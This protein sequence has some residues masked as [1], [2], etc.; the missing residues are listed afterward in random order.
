[1]DLSNNLNSLENLL[2]YKFSN[3][4]F[5]K[6]SLTHRSFSQENNE[7]YEFLGDSIINLCASIWLIN[8]HKDLSEGELSS[9]RSK[10]VSRKNLGRLAKN[11]KLEEFVILGNSISRKKIH[12]TEILGNTFESIVAAIY[13]DSNFEI[14]SDWLFEVFEKQSGLMDLSLEKDSKT[15][16]QE[17]LQKRQLSLPKYLN[18]SLKEGLFESSIVSE[19]NK[20]FSGKGSS[21]KEAEK[22]AAENYLKH[23]IKDE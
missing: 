14:T 6:L 12:Q 19:Q 16:L 5:L 13:L 21:I 17:F 11:F 8:N 15:E 22:K 7:T 23:L 2:S 9:L 18:T 1:M 10:V 20:H 4:E 3:K